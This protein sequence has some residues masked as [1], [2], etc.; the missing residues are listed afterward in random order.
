M[1]RIV[2]AAVTHLVP[3]S[4][5]GTRTGSTG[6]EPLELEQALVPHD[7]V[8]RDPQIRRPVRS[9]ARVERGEA[10]AGRVER[11]DG[12]PD[13]FVAHKLVA[14]A[15]A[16]RLE[17]D[18]FEVDDVDLG[19]ARETVRRDRVRGGREVVDV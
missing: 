1:A 10:P 9:L 15:D 14:L 16:G 17:R 11:A 3:M 6:V 4:G 5:D 2:P 18:R 8:A 12:R 13:A 7:D 19:R